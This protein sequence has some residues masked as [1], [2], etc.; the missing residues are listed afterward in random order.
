MYAYA[1]PQNASNPSTNSQT[2]GWTRVVSNDGEFSIE[3]PVKHTFFADQ[4][5]FIVGN[6]SNDFELKNMYM[7]TAYINGTL[8]SFEVFDGSK[9]AFDA[10][11]DVDALDKS[12]RSATTKKSDRAK[13][14]EVIN[15]TN[16]Y[17]SIRRFINTKS[18]IYVVTAANRKGETAE[19]KRF[20]NSLVINDGSSPKLDGVAFSSLQP[21]QVTIN[22]AAPTPKT[23][24]VS[25]VPT[26]TP[27]PAVRPLVVLRV[28]RGSYLPLARKHNLQGAVVLKVVMAANGSIPE[29]TVVNSLPDGLDRQSIFAALRTKFLPKEKNDAPV[30]VTKTLEFNYNIY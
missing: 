25:P 14:K 1:W 27:D 13:I 21:Q 20:L 15:S 10:L 7:L 12:G 3:V 18:H 23:N 24:L 17:Y 6:N 22:Y 5:G 30:N 19:L 26:P 29:I 16:T 11:Y 28:T 9:G 8:V 4:A 2:S